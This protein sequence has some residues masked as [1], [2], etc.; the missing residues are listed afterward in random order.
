MSSTKDFVLEVTPSI[1]HDMKCLT[2]LNVLKFSVKHRVPPLIFR[3]RYWLLCGSA[4]C[5]VIPGVNCY[6]RCHTWVDWCIVL[7]QLVFILLLYF[8]Q[9]P[10]DTLTIMKGIGAQLE[11][12]KML[13]FQSRTIFI[14]I[15]N[16]I[17]LVIHE[18]F[19]N[20]GQ[21]IFYL[22]FLTK[23]FQVERPGKDSVIQVV[24]GEFFPRKDVL[25]TVLKLSRQ[26]L[27]GESKRYWRRVPGQGLK[28]LSKLSE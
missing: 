1:E 21:V 16:V 23:N 14:P 8:I 2:T 7:V 26:L 11:S 20:Y 9:E 12:R 18:G 27:F 4:I 28:E 19:H 5:L 10:R 6:K 24:F 3:G 15:N 17:D 13:P 22:C 25:L